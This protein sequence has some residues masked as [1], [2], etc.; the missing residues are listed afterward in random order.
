[1]VWGLSAGGPHTLACAALLPKLVVAAAELA[2]PA[3]YDAKGLDWFEGMDD[4]TAL[5]FKIAVKGREE[6]DQY[7]RDTT[8]G[9]FTL[10]ANQLYASWLSVNQA[11]A[12]ALRNKAYANYL[13]YGL[14]AS[15]RN[16]YGGVDDD[17]AFTKPWGFNLKQIKIPVLVMQGETDPIVPIAH[18]KWLAANIPQAEAKFYPEDGHLSMVRH[19]PEVH[20]W[21]LSQWKK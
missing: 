21:L 3:P 16:P 4:A 17:V 2:S 14:F 5:E 9:V 6:V 1:M 7:L 15:V 12:E 8:A 19:I 20:D 11:D 13:L 18:G 10:D